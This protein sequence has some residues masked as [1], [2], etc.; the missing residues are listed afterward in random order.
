MLE[1]NPLR[2]ISAK[3]ALQHPYFDDLD[4][5]NGLNFILIEYIQWETA[6]CC[7]ASTL[8]CLKGPTNTEEGTY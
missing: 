5:V 4:K 7:P 2:R 6:A 1:Y 3:M 8:V